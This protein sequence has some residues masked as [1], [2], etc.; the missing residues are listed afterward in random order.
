MS[1]RL[2]VITISILFVKK[3]F[4][5]RHE[6]ED[7]GFGPYMR[8]MD[9]VDPD[10][11]F[12]AEFIPTD[13]LDEFDIQ[14]LFNSADIFTNALG[15]KNPGK[16]SFGHTMGCHPGYV[17]VLKKEFPP[18]GGHAPGYHVECCTFPGT[19]W[20]DDADDLTLIDVHVQVNNGTQ[21]A[22]KFCQAFDPENG[23]VPHP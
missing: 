18:G 12:G 11:I 21:T 19:V 9:L 10:D 17:L 6:I 7:W 4:A 23:I 8:D 5:K 13:S 14:E 1:R 2:D 16:A 22:K 15:L 3:K 20:T